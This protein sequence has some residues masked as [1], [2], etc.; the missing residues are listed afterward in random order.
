[1]KAGRASRWW[2]VGPKNDKAKQSKGEPSPPSQRKMWSRSA[3]SKHSNSHDKT[4]ANGRNGRTTTTTSR[5]TAIMQPTP[6]QSAGKTSHL[7]SE[8]PIGP[9][10]ASLHAEILS[11][12]PVYDI[13]AVAR[14]CKRLAR[15]VRCDHRVWRRRCALLELKVDVDIAKEPMSPISPPTSRESP[16]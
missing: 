6:L 11:Y 12:L 5:F 4:P 13:P 16:V 14:V 9:L 3:A 7:I 10:P 1:M 15:V 2:V 8:P